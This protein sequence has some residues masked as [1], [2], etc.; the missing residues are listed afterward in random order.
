MDALTYRH[1]VHNDVDRVA[2]HPLAVQLPMCYDQQLI[3]IDYRCL[4]S[5]SP[6]VHISTEAAND[7]FCKADMA[8]LH[9]VQCHF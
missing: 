6:Q 1:S 8:D 9:V 3:V 5:H 4:K 2:N 7:W